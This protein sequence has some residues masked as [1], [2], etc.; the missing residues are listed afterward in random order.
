MK[1]EIK[2]RAKEI[3][4]TL[5][6]GEKLFGKFVYGSL[7]IGNGLHHILV[8]D[9]EKHQF[10][11]YKVAPDT[12]G[13][14]TGLH[15]KNGRE[16]YEGDIIKSMNNDLYHVI[17]YNESR[18]AF[19]ATLINKYMYDSDGMKTECNAEQKWLA[20]YKKI[21]IGNIHD[22]PELLKGGAQ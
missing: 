10:L 4:C 8:P 9:P 2:F 6:N 22:N 15:D 1:R 13:Q 14:F 17:G 16:I 7:L 19:T 5:P 18:G 21:I 20:D 11:N 12:I 3:Q